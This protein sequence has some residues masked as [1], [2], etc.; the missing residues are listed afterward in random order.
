MSDSSAGPIRVIVAGTGWGCLA[1]VPALRAAGFEVAA[2]VGNDRERTA[3]RARRLASQWR[4]RASN[5]RSLY[6]VSGPPLSL[7]RRQLTT[8]LP[9]P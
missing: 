7:R 5:K 8:N 3:D 4:P 9:P 2:L 1:H 6:P